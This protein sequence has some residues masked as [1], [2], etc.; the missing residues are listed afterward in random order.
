MQL[1]NELLS[2]HSVHVIKYRIMGLNTNMQQQFRG[3]LNDYK[4]L[5]IFRMNNK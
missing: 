1:L 2:Y 5:S 3:D 4:Y